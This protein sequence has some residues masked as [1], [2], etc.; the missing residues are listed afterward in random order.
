M[1]FENQV[2]KPKVNYT[3]NTSQIAGVDFN[4]VSKSYAV[5]ST[6]N[7]IIALVKVDTTTE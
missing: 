3:Q 1:K 6:Q 4:P 5:F 2:L 7:G